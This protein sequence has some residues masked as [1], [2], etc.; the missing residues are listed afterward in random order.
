MAS[1]R[2]AHHCRR[3]GNHSQIRRGITPHQEMLPGDPEPQA[4]MKPPPP[5]RGRKSRRT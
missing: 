4:G 1:R 2:A 5:R 3:R